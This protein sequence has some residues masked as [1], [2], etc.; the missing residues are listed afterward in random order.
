MVV[1]WVIAIIIRKE[2]WPPGQPYRPHFIKENGRVLLSVYL[3]R[4]CRR[5]PDRILDRS[6]GAQHLR[7]TRQHVLP[8]FWSVFALFVAVHPVIQVTQLLGELWY[9]FRPVTWVQHIAG[10]PPRRH[11]EA[12]K[13]PLGLP[14]LVPKE[15]AQGEEL[16]SNK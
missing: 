12:K 7:Y 4:V 8:H 15:T 3:I 2:I 14:D 5:I 9:W 16:Y 13:P 1:A 11:M 6:C 10:P